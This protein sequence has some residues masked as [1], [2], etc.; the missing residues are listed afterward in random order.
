MEGITRDARPLGRSRSAA[1]RSNLKER[2][3]ALWPRLDRRALRRCSDDPVRI[4]RLV[5]RRTLLPPETII[6][7]L[8]GGVTDTDR[9]LWFG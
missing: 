9:E 1:P 5:A 3:L 4:A 6:E 8:G 2:A 7:I